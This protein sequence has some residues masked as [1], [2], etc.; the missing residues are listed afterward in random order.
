[1]LE[2]PAY[3]SRRRRRRR[4]KKGIGASKQKLEMIAR[5]E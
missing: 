4:R 1:V 3:E 2:I 5:V